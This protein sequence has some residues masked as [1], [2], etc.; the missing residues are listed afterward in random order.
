MRPSRAVIAAAALYAAGAIG[1]VGC[2]DEGLP[3]DT[4]EVDAGPGVSDTT[5]FGTD[6]SV[7]ADAAA[8]DAEP[9]LDGLLEDAGGDATQTAS[10][11][12]ASDP[13]DGVAGLDAAPVL[14]EVAAPDDALEDTGGPPDDVPQPPLSKPGPPQA[15]ASNPAAGQDGVPIPFTVSVT[16]DESLAANTLV[17]QT[18]QLRNAQGEAVPIAISVAGEGATVLIE[19]LVAEWDYASPYTVWFQ[20]GIV[21][22][23]GGDKLVENLE[24]TFYTE[25]WP[26]LEAYEDLAAQYAPELSVETYGVAPQ[27]MIPTVFNADGDWDGSNTWSWIQS[28]AE[29]LVPSVHW[30]AAETYT[31]YFIHYVFVWPWAPHPSGSGYTHANGS[32]GALV[33]VEKATASMEQR[34]VAVMAYSKVKGAEDHRT[35]VT[36]E[37]GLVGASGAAFYGITGEYAQA[38]L[39]P[40]DRYHGWLS[41]QHESCV[42]LDESFDALDPGCQITAADKA[43]FI[44][45]ELAWAAGDP[46]PI[47]KAGLGFPQTNSQIDGSPETVAYGLTP[48]LDTLWARRL[49]IGN[50]KVFKGTFEYFAEADRPGWGLSLPKAFVDPISPVDNALG[51]PVWA[52]EHDPTTG[53]ISVIEQGWVGVDPAW[54]VWRRHKG[55][56]FD[57]SL[58]PWNAADETGFSVDYCFAPFA[59]IDAR[60]EHAL[61]PAP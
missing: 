55:V 60:G 59:G 32:A 10:D 4:G 16:F 24:I 27:S 7:A 29:A 36:T 13:G 57:S 43:D 25:S 6:G 26:D 3:V 22:D 17:D 15:I 14:D 20:G 30:V 44:G 8:S 42:W 50:S 56:A 34:P 23:L 40:G 37:S 2:G 19:P 1:A 21:S 54:Y 58:K 61:C 46:P 5:M 51:R 47:V 31:H 53:D 49:E 48:V 18:V 9:A 33:V 28:D 45:L 11:G 35:Y 39:F 52:W 38:T 12:A 41:A